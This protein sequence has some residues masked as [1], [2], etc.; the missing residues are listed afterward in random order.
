M[1][2][3]KKFIVFVIALLIAFASLP[4]S[5]VQAAE[6]ISFYSSPS[7]ALEKGEGGKPL[8]YLFDVDVRCV[9]RIAI[10]AMK[11]SDIRIVIHNSEDKLIADTTLVGST[12]GYD[13]SWCMYKYFYEMELEQGKGYKLRMTFSQDDE[14]SMAIGRTVVREMPEVKLTKGFSTQ[15][16]ANLYEVASWECSDTKIAT[17]ENGKVVGK[18]LGNTTITATIKDDLRLSW[19]IEVLENAYTEPKIQVPSKYDKKRY[20]QVYKAYFSG[21]K[22]ILKARIVNNTKVDYTELRNLKLEIK[23]KNGKTI[24]TYKNSKKNVKI[25]KRSAKN[26]T[27][28]ID[29]PK[30]KNVDLREAKVSIKGTLFHYK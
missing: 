3:I 19:K 9:T 29:K 2:E 4:V 13:E 23:T 26:L 5:Y 12:G 7:E 10:V 28:V 15:L 25:P 8:E 30:L 16:D 11:Q 27:F 24:G 1:E 6:L 14:F 21:K 22:L 20:M 17:I 18:K